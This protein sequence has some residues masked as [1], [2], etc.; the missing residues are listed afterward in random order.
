VGIERCSHLFWSAS[1]EADG[2]DGENVL[3]CLKRALKIANKAQEVRSRVT[4]VISVER[5]I[6]GPSTLARRQITSRRDSRPSA[7]DA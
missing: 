5:F 1:R 2:P 3:L 7:L 6:V 4:S